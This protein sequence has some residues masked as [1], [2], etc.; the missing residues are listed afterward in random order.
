MALGQAGATITADVTAFDAD[1][2][3]TW[4]NVEMVVNAQNNDDAGPNNNIGWQALGSHAVTRDGQPQTL[5]WMLPESLTTAISGVDDNISWFELA[6]V[7]NLDAASVTRF[8]VDNIQLVNE[9]P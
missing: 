8:Y 2:T 6:L 7:S 5:T 4:M 9:A 1:M 3:T